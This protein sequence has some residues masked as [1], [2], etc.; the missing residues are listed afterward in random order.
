MLLGCL[1]EIFFRGR[2]LLVGVEPRSIV[3]FLGKKVGSLKGSVWAEQL[4][5][6]DVLQYVVADAGLPLQAGIAQVQKQR[7]EDNQGSLASALDV[8][9]TKNEACKALAINWNQVERDW[10]A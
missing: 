4:K 10:D 1:D 6:W 8:F 3:W 7:R 9:H 5:A 2:P